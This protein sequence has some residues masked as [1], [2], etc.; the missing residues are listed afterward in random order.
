MSDAKASEF[1]QAARPLVAGG[2]NEAV[3][4][5]KLEQYLPLIFPDLPW[6]VRWHAEGAETHTKFEK[7]GSLRHGFIDTLIG[8]TAVEYEP[9]LTKL[10]VEK[11]AMD[12]VRDYVAGQVNSNVPMDIIVG[13]VSDT[14]RW[15]AFH[16]TIVAGSED[17]RPIG[18]SD[19]EL[20]VIDAID[21]T[22]PSSQ[23][24]AELK[25]FLERHLGRIGSR[26]LRGRMLATDLGLD[27][28]AG[29]GIRSSLDA[30]E[31]A[32]R[33]ERPGY[34]K[35][36]D[37]LWSELVDT[38]GSKGVS[39]SLGLAEYLDEFYLITLAKL[40]CAN[41]VDGSAINRPDTDLA[42]ILD[43]TFF[44][45]RGLQN[46]V[47]Y[48][49]FGWLSES[50]DKT[51]MLEV[52]RAIQDD[53]VAYD[54]ATLIKDDLF[55]QLLAGLGRKS[56]RLILGQEL[57]PPWLARKMVERVS[58]TLGDA[59]LRMIDTA[60]GS[61]TILVEAIRHEASAVAGT[62][63]PVERAR[64]IADSATGFDIDPLAALF[65]KTN[66]VIAMREEL[67][68]L[69]EIAIPVFHADSLF[70]GLSQQSADQVVLKL[71]D[72]SVTPPAALLDANG[73]VVFDQI[74]SNAYRIAMK[75]AKGTSEPNTASA[76]S[77]ASS[78]I[79]LASDAKPFDLGEVTE[80]VASLITELALL[81]RDGRNGL[82]SYVIRNTS[83][84][85]QSFSQFNAMVINPPWLALSKIG[86]NPYA[87]LLDRLAEQLGVRPAGQSFL[88]TELSAV[89]LLEGVRR[90]LEAGGVFGCILPSTIAQGHHQNRFRRG[91]YAGAGRQVAM[92]VDEI[93][94]IPHGVF[95]NEAIVLFGQKVPFQAR[96][97]IAGK[98]VDEDG[99]EDRPF[100]AV[101]AVYD[102]RPDRVIWT[103]KVVGTTKTT[104]F[105]FNPAAFRQG[106]DL[107]PRTAWFHDFQAYGAGRSK[108]MPIRSGDALWYLLRD[109]HRETTFRLKSGLVVDDR[110]LARAVLSN[111]LS[112]FS[113]APADRLILPAAF[114]GTN[115][116]ALI[117]A[118]LA[119]ASQGTID[120]FDSILNMMDSDF[121]GLFATVDLMGKLR[122]QT[123]DADSYIVLSGAGGAN[124]CA[125]WID[126]GTYVPGEIVFDQTVYWAPVGTKDEA[127]YL[128]GA[129]NSP[130]CA[131]LI[132][133]FQPRGAQG[134]RHIHKLPFSITP[135]FNP[136]DDDHVELAN[137]TI[138]LEAAWKTALTG[139]PALAAKTL[140]THSNLQ[141]RRR[142]AMALLQALPEWPRYE[143]A[144]A[145]LYGGI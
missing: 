133:P 92:D 48:D 15:K 26:P 63:D 139:T 5:K 97:A 11:H 76:C 93:W 66:W 25:R 110:F 120:A 22:T 24:G 134:R 114:T 123:W 81:Q 126:P 67:P 103:P 42:S 43:G 28:L 65:A 117:D 72:S 13:V 18:R 105:G 54:F 21:L 77:V 82:W 29:S 109:A 124:P 98:S 47:E 30:I 1:L 70:A 145:N 90:Y 33:A 144:A 143:S 86:G 88:H 34:G 3:V 64:R 137:A 32:A 80:F 84:A 106:A 4:R 9:D 128:A 41:V 136:E 20:D 107:M 8:A 99:H 53:L 141:N 40:I 12:Q 16:P 46:Y 10:G 49:L 74:L 75:E 116:R 135:P 127:A 36:I 58:G 104:G 37:R 19:I 129:V 132:R 57:T 78:A 69:G 14:L 140:P 91:A 38:I 118:D 68:H 138:A 31:Q 121:G 101:T 35:L 59:P 83:R 119:T 7:D 131:E 17:K 39:R 85:A 94:S 50:P 95:K 100:E 44:S 122:R 27:S 79:A 52:A 73:R 61:G 45:G 112:P 142:W 108:V 60:C 23:D 96:A 87:T 125:A 115:W 71:D 102:G 51:G 56:T 89:F 130:A 2:A 6:W 111:Q 62:H 55:G 113:V